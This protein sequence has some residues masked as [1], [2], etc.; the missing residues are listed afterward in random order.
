[1]SDEMKEVMDS[2]TASWS[3]TAS[4]IEK[5]FSVTRPG[6]VFSEPVS[7]EGH[8]IITT[9]EVM[10]GMG[11]GYGIGAGS[12]TAEESEEEDDQEAEVERS[13][14]EGYGG[15]GGGGGFS[16]GRP[17]AAIIIEPEGVRIEPIVDVTKLGLAFFT[18]LG[19]IFLM[20]L[21]MRRAAGG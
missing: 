20:G 4:V 5:L 14:G 1:M 3:A 12:A 10:V 11:V 13:G 7:A 6:A 8:T 2:T 21:R 16:T 9:S 17:V 18:M 15:G 19:S